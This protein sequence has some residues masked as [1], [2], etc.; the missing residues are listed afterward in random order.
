M[1]K[2]L[3]LIVLSL[4]LVVSLAAC[5]GGAAPAATPEPA[6]A[7]ATS[8]GN[9]EPAATGPDASNPIKIGGLMAMTGGLA[10]DGEDFIQAIDLAVSMRNVDGVIGRTVEFVKEDSG[11]TPDTAVNA[12]NKVLRDTSLDVVFGP[13]FSSQ[14]LAIAD[15]INE[16]EPMHLTGSQSLRVPEAVTNPTSA[17]FRIPDVY[18]AMACATYLVQELKVEKVGLLIVNDDFGQS[19]KERIIAYLEDNGVDYVVETYGNED[20]DMTT[21]IMNLKNAGIDSLVCW[22]YNDVFVVAARQLFELGVTDI[23]L[24]SNG[25]VTNPNSLERMESDWYDGWF[26]ITEWNPQGTDPVSVEFNNNFVS[27]YNRSPNF[28][29]ASWHSATHYYLDAVEKA[30]TTEKFAV[31]D[32]MKAMG[33]YESLVGIWSWTGED[34]RILCKSMSVVQVTEGPTITTK[35]VFDFR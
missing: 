8:G 6:P 23:P 34:P 7:P 25:A 31:V 24:F 20:K 16:T 15:L 13:H 4:I 1:K 19:A 33:D 14:M 35:K 12:A 32:A 11:S 5:G 3:L 27:T 2:K 28:L 26:C 21:Q 29:S 18:A 10:S 17:W 22:S 30:G 9:D